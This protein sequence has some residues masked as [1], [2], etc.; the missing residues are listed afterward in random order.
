MIT[1]IGIVCVRTG[2]LDGLIGY[3]WDIKP[4]GKSDKELF[5]EADPGVDASSSTETS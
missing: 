5:A 2:S 3:L 4:K 1:K